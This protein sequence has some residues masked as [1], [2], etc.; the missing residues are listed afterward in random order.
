VIRNVGTAPVPAVTEQE[1]WVDLY[2]DP[3]PLP[4]Y[5]DPWSDVAEQGGVWGITTAGLPLAPGQALTLTVSSA[6]GD[7]FYWPEL[8]HLSWPLS[9]TAQ[10][11]AQVDS[12]NLETDYGGVQ[13]A[14]ETNNLYGPASPMTR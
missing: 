4:A 8:S 9:A 3:D 12:T 1:F 13:E 2:V 6:G 10:L 11:Y 5:N 7:F 14:D